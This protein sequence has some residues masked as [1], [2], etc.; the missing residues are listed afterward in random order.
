M[1]QILNI[2]ED[3][4]N[5]RSTKQFNK[6]MYDVW[7]LIM[8]KEVTVQRQQTNSDLSEYYNYLA[9]Q[10]YYG[11][12]YGGYGGYGGYGNQ[13]TNYYNYMMMAQYASANSSY[14]SVSVELDKDRFYRASL[15]GPA[16][17]GDVPTLKLVF[18]IPKE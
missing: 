3:D 17:S 8:S 15:N 16:G 10:S 4:P 5:A 14:E 12:M 18:S 7:F 13:Y 1:Q 2:K 6:G 11:S 9:Y